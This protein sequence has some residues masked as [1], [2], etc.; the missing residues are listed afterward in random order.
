M[1]YIRGPHLRHVLR[2]HVTTLT[3]SEHNSGLGLKVQGYDV[4]QTP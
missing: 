1:G 3:Y 4:H 2:D